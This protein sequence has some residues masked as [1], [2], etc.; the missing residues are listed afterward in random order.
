MGQGDAM[1]RFTFQPT[2]AAVLHVII[3]YKD[4]CCAI[5]KILFSQNAEDIDF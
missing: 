5:L 3:S 1:D 2:A 4:I